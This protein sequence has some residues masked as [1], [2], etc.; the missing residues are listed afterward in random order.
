MFGFGLKCSV[1]GCSKFGLNV[2]RTS[3]TSGG[4]TTPLF[5]PTLSDHNLDFFPS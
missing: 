4:D 5:L 1:R 3:R 2:R